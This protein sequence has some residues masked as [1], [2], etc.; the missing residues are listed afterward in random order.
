MARR[1]RG[2]RGSGKERQSLLNAAAN[3]L[4]VSD[5]PDS[6]WRPMTTGDGRSARCGNVFGAVPMVKPEDLREN[7]QAE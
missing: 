7:R 1:R 4:V 2:C 3:R 6:G 5:E